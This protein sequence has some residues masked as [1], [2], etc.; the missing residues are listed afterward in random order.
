MV[1]KVVHNL[2]WSINRVDGAAV[3]EHP[4]RYSS[5]PGDAPV[6]EVIAVLQQALH[7]VD[8]LAID[9]ERF[10]EQGSPQQWTGGLIVAA[11]QNMVDS[12]RPR[13][14]DEVPIDL[15]AIALQLLL[16]VEAIRDALCLIHGFAGKVPKQLVGG[17]VPGIR[18]RRRGTVQAP[19]RTRRVVHAPLDGERHQLE[20]GRDL[21]DAHLSPFQKRSVAVVKVSSCLISREH[22][23]QQTSRAGDGA[24]K[25]KKEK[26][27]G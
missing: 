12:V 8:V 4:R 27:F 7:I 16:V 13:Q 10:E 5:C 22:M 26:R 23:S 11:P 25:V 15:E 2:L 20:L 14:P 18:V 21:L 24:S 6:R 17:P 1:I 3:L 19:V 9:A